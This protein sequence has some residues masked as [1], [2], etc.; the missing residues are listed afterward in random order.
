MYK[1]LV[2]VGV[3]L[4]FLGCASIVNSASSNETISVHSR[5]PNT[6]FVVYD[7]YNNVVDRGFAPRS[8]ILSR[9]I[10][11]FER[12]RYRIDSFVGTNTA[13]SS[14]IISA[15]VTPS[16]IVGNFFFG[17]LIGWLIVDPLTGSM[18]KYGAKTV[19]I[20]PQP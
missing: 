8:I 11:Y 2:G 17:A 6:Q 10:G 12:P 4:S 20:T 1:A 18:W 14:T 16:Y 19:D 13:T 5:V 3:S 7:N 9:N 15:S